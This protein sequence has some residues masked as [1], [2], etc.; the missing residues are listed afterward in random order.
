MYVWETVVEITVTDQP[1][2]GHPLIQLGYAYELS[3]RE[4]AMEALGLT[5]IS[6]NFLHQYIDDPSYS[7]PSPS[8]KSS[9]PIVVLQKVAEDKRFDSLF[10]HQGADNI[11]PLFQ[12]HEA[13]VLDHW[14][15]WQL[16]NP[17]EQFE[18]SQY[19]AVALL[20]GT[21]HTG[22]D[23]KHDFFLVHLL[24]TSHAVRILLPLL[25]SRYHLTIVKQWWLITLAVYI[26][27][28]RPEIDLSSIKRYVLKGKDWDWVDKQAVEGKWSLDSHYVKASRAMKEAAKTWGDDEQYY[29]KAAMKFAE[30][31][32]GWGGFGPL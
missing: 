24:T 7:N 9:D 28:L 29:L 26:A 19:A 14:N 5:A 21:H 31:F 30:E 12:D 17:K 2:V 23:R 13:A 18:K 1:L 22:S 20:V 25:P 6:Y 15:A 32:D 8:Y 3:S 27:Q 4:I 11:E 16:P 10:D